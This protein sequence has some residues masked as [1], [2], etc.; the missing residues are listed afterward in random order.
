MNLYDSE[1]ISE[2][3]EH[4]GYKGVPDPKRAAVVIIN[5]CSVRDRAERKALSRMK[6]FAA[7]RRDRSGR[8]RPGPAIVVAG[9]MAQRMGSRLT[10]DAGAD[11]VA[12]FDAYPEIPSLIE[13]SARRGGAVVATSSAP[14][15]LHCLSP[16][17]H[18]GVTAFVTIMQGCNNF[19]SYC[20]VPYVRGR[21][22]SKTAGSVIEEIRRLV[23]LGVKEVTLLG[24][25]VN[26][27]TSGGAG[28]HDLL[29]AANGVAGLERIRFTTSH[30]KDL[31]RGLVEAM[32][33]L[34]KVCEHLHLPLQSA[35][36]RILRM[37]NRNY[38]GSDFRK[39]VDFARYTVP[40]LAITT[41]LM[42]GFPSESDAD[43]LSTR[44]ALEDIRFD[45][46]FMF[47]YSVREGTQ[48]AG[49]ADDIPSEVKTRRLQDLLALQNAITDER[50]RAF[51][52]REVEVLL[53]DASSREP[54]FMLGRTRENWLAKVPAKGVKRG[55]TVVANVSAVTRWMI[56]CEPF[57]RKVGA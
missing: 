18:A 55:E 47:R 7:L 42:V 5:T 45:A 12:G 33:D 16:R 40:G 2:V 49:L 23:D 14:S 36:D 28:F 19:C 3:M 52:G 57:L 41:D 26:S 20:V 30:P 46:A 44:K 29:A 9:C 1:F 25:N 13:D 8:R 37:M 56:V 22:Q 39:L 32:R 38:T 6:E 48:A 50:K 35:S 53:E 17:V 54:G 43:H 34:P 15:F 4:A 10:G 31:T 51:V 21:E 11:V 27:Y 24:Q